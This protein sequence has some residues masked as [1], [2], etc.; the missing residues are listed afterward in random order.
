MGALCLEIRTG[1]ITI[2]I[3]ISTIIISTMHFNSAL[4][5]SL[6]S[7]NFIL[8]FFFFWP[9]LIGQICFGCNSCSDLF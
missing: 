1:F 3:I 5:Y 9:V 2:I 6:Q 8:T 4:G 7:Y